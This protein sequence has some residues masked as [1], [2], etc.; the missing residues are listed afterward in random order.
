MLCAGLPLYFDLPMLNLVLQLSNH[1]LMLRPAFHMLG[2]YFDFAQHGAA[3]Q[4]G[5]SIKPLYALHSMHYALCSLPY[6]F[7]I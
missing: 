7:R 1:P 5:T 4:P 6:A 3:Q 2:L